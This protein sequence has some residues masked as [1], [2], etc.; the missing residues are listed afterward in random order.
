MVFDEVEKDLELLGAT[1]VEDR[2]VPC[3]NKHQRKIINCDLKVYT[4]L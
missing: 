4:H 1:A 2:Y 3:C